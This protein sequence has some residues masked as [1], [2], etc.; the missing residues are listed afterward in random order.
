MNNF[1]VVILDGVGAGELPDAAKYGDE[2]SNTLANIASQCGGLHLPA[3]QQLGLG[4]I[5]SIDGTPPVAKPSASFGKMAEASSGKDSTTGHWELGGVHVPFE[6]SYY[7]EGFPGEIMQRFLA[8]NGLEGYLWN[9]PASG[10]E[11]IKEFGDE[12]LRTGYPIV[13]TSADSVFQI[14][15]HEEVIPI[16]RQYEICENTRHKVLTPPHIVG[17]VIARPFIGESGSFQRTTNRKDYSLDPPSPTVLNLLSDA[18]ITTVAIGKINDL[19]NYSGIA[20][21]QKTK[22]NA[23]GMQRLIEAASEHDN[24]FIMANLVDFDVYF[25]HRNDPEGFAGALREVDQWLPSFLQEL[26]ESDALVITA[27]HGNDPTS[28]STDHSREYVPVLYYQKGA[29]VRD[30]GVRESF[31]D[32][33]CTAADFFQLNHTFPGRKF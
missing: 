11:I 1:F 20:V 2:G 30:L 27:D 14:A 15:A 7:P 21:Q 16:E 18:G 5:T 25:G 33:A 8:V 24:S 9:K 13:Y 28:T 26:D 23:E 32:V 17:R 22:S 10:T 3:L 29:P 4:N 6:F 19:Y 31:S 12:H